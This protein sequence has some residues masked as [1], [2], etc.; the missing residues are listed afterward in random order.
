MVKL[1]NVEETMETSQAKCSS[2]EKTKLCLQT[3]IE[4]LL[5]ELERTNAAALALEKRQRN[6]DKVGDASRLSP[7]SQQPCD[8][9][10]VISLCL[11]DSVVER[12]EAEV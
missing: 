1:Q 7:L 12:L 10:Y 3:E 11:F 6:F 9:K 2:L 5:V 4:E 8:V